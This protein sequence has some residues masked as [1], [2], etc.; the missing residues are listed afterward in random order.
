[1]FDDLDKTQRDL[2]QKKRVR[3]QN[4]LAR[5]ARRTNQK[6]ERRIASLR[7]VE[8]A[9]IISRA[10]REMD[11]PYEIVTGCVALSE[12]REHVVGKLL[13]GT[14]AR[15]HIPTSAPLPQHMPEPFQHGVTQVY[16]IQGKGRGK[17]EDY[18]LIG[19][20]RHDGGATLSI[21]PEKK[22][23]MRAVL[24]A[25]SPTMAFGLMMEFR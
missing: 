5:Q 1:M 22:I 20:V 23:D 2:L 18:T 6:T 24:R 16:R 13:Y 15:L 9:E 10:L 7:A 11:D 25:T 21:H 12:F 14:L 3:Q 4:K 8:T 17:E 19:Y